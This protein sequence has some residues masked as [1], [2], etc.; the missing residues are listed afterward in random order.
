MGHT[1]TATHPALTAR[2]QALVE[3]VLAATPHFLVEFE[4]RGARG[5]RVLDLY[6]DSD[7]DLDVDELA[8]I[9]REVGFL[10]DTEDLIDGRYHLNVSSPGVDRPLKL[11]RQYRKNVGRTLQVHYQ[12]P[13]GNGNTETT[14]EL[15]AAD[16]EGIDVM[17]SADERR[18]IP[19]D[20]ILWARVK[21][22]W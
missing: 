11:P 21:L 16:E 10:L 18:R 20:D 17:H 13:E 5:S 14:G 19:Y 7:A 12:K 9:S 4:L 1:T 15:V 8:R 2:I 22:P 3:E 6:V